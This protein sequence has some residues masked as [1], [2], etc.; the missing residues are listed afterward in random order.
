MEMYYSGRYFTVTGYHLEGTPTTIEARQTELEALHK[1][2]F[3]KLKT[4]PKTP[5]PARPWTYQTSL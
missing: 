4:P 1:E 5:T 3:G 2:M